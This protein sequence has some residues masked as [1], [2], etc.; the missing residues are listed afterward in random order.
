MWPSRALFCSKIYLQD[1]RTEEL[2]VIKLSTSAWFSKSIGPVSALTAV[3]MGPMSPP[4]VYVV[5]WAPVARLALYSNEYVPVEGSVG[6]A[7][8]CLPKD[9]VT[10]HIYR[11]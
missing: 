1:R 4:H 7:K 2:V 11:P 10:M 6:V 3:V 9:T 8:S 5:F